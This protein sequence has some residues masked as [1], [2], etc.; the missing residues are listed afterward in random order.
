MFFVIINNFVF[1]KAKVYWNKKIIHIKENL[2]MDYFMV[3][4]K[5]FIKTEIYIKE[6]LL[7]V[8]RMDKVT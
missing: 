3:K 5:L 2:N 4:V 1:L 8:W 7:M 6:I